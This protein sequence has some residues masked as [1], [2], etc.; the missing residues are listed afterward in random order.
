MILSPH[1]MVLAKL[2]R[3]RRRRHKLYNDTFFKQNIQCPPSWIN[4]N[5]CNFRS[6]II[7]N[8]I[9]YKLKKN[10]EQSLVF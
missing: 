9:Q 3:K 5:G 6:C 4:K 7:K 2:L 10:T 8:I 1:C